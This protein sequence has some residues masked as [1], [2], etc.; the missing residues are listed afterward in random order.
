MP[1]LDVLRYHAR[2]RH[3]GGGALVGTQ[4]QLLADLEP[5]LLAPDTASAEKRQKLV[6]MAA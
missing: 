4:Y 2:R 5:A 1:L 6:V 3:F